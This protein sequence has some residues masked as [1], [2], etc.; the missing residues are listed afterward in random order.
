MLETQ[1]TVDVVD[2]KMYALTGA[3]PTI[4]PSLI[5]MQTVDQS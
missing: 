1:Q 4:M 3:K 2:R 5:L